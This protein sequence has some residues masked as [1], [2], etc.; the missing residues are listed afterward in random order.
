[1]TGWNSPV[2]HVS[3][4]HSHA[5]KNMFQNVAQPLSRWQPSESRGLKWRGAED[6]PKE[7]SKKPRTP[8]SL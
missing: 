4:N 2:S 3:A 6:G 1:M 7:G 8:G 5:K